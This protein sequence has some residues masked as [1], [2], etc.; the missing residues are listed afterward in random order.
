MIEDLSE[1]YTISSQND[2]ICYYCHKRVI[3][4]TLV[5]TF[6]GDLVVAEV[7]LVVMMVVVME[8]TTVDWDVL[9]KRMPVTKHM[10]MKPAH[11]SPL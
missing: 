9:N 10:M 1:P 3:F 7:G 11:P 6:M 5:G 8:V 4:E 2:R